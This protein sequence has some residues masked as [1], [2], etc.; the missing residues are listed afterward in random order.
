[1]DRCRVT[2]SRSVGL[3]VLVGGEDEPEK[4]QL[5]SL[6]L[7]RSG[8]RIV[9]SPLSGARSVE[10]IRNPLEKAIL[11]YRGA[12]AYAI[13][14]RFRI[15][16]DRRA[17]WFNTVDG[18]HRHSPTGAGKGFEMISFFKWAL[19]I[20]ICLAVTGQLKTATLRMAKMA[21]EAQKHQVSY[22]KFSRMLT[23]PGPRH[24]Q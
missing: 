21:V 2:C 1:M 13:R 3:D 14:G 5:I 17:A 15:T 12:G 16:A 10:R 6:R 18:D 11:R 9:R 4:N 7:A 22:G 23:A 20:T 19:G 24:R 8:E